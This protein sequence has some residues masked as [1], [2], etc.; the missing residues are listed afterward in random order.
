MFINMSKSEKPG[1]PIRDALG[2]PIS[3]VDP[4][5][6][7]PLAGKWFGYRAVG[8]GWSYIGCFNTEVDARVAAGLPTG[9]GR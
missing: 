6:S 3:Y 5:R 2:Q 9:T 8:G 7:P 1:S 4:A